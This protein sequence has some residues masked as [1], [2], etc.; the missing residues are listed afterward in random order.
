MSSV[1]RRNSLNT[2]EAMNSMR[3]KVKLR[4]AMIRSHHTMCTMRGK[5]TKFKNGFMS[6]S[7]KSY[8]FGGMI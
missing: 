6:Q 8:L 5:V 4:Q 7:Y 1:D 3:K 2:E